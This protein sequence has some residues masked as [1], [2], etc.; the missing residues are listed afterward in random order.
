MGEEGIG[1]KGL[2]TKLIINYLPQSM[3]DGEFH[4]LF[5][6]IGPVESTNV[7]RDR[8]TDYS[9]GYGF[10]DYTNPADAATAISKLNGYKILHKTLRVAYSKPPGSSKNV[11]LYLVGLTPNT[12]ERALEELF[13]PYGDLVYTRILRN[14][15]GSSKSVG[16]VLFKEKENAERAM[17]ELQ[18]HTDDT[19][20]NLQIKYAKDQTD[21]KDLHPKYQE[22]LQQKFMQQNMGMGGGGGM[23]MGGMGMGMGRGGM[24]G[25]QQFPSGP[26]YQD[27]YGGGFSANPMSNF[28]GQKAMRGRDVSSRFN[29]ISRPQLGAGAGPGMGMGMGGKG[30]G[31][32]VGGGPAPMGNDPNTTN[33][34]CYFGMDPSDADVY[35][36]FSKFGRITKVD[37][38]RG[39][40]YAFIHMPVAEEANEALMALNG[41]PWQDG[42][43]LQVSVR[44]AK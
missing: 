42:K 2:K 14:Q 5:S 18:G 44:K 10:V 1:S 17:R 43:T 8:K 15:D 7:M 22:F 38:V 33:L 27:P 30:M 36:L 32:G 28:G 13:T 40:G 4:S 31:M 19:G 9:Y 41:L 11:N 12:D 3:T 29:P 6:A 23:G 37:I 24:G 26:M 20:L 16:F 21:P 39:K 35:S 25:F 34:F